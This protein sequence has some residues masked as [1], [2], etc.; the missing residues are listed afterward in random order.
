MKISIDPVMS[1][2]IKTAWA[3]LTPAQQ[4]QLT[5]AILQAHQQA[6]SV[7]QTGKA[8][9][10]PALPHHLML[11]QSALN[12]DQDNVVGN[13]DAGIVLDVGS[14]GVIWGT[15]KYEQLDPGWLEA[16]AVFLE[17]F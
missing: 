11:A 15:S 8:P 4:S 2:R 10:E 6:K 16:F 17:T 7:S 13:L 1:G 5:P 12:D 9:V 3:K 14:D